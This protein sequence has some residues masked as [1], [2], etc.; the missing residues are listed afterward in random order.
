[1]N[2]NADIVWNARKPITKEGFGMKARRELEKVQTPTNL[3]LR[4]N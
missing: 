2:K 4:N 1:M 3:K